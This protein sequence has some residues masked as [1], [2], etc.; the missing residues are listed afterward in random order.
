MGD[1]KKNSNG[2]CR[3]LGVVSLMMKFQMRQWIMDA[4]G[5]H[6]TDD[7]TKVRIWPAELPCG[8][9]PRRIDEA[10]LV[11]PRRGV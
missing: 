5:C 11:K 2:S 3:N 1:G 6:A 10:R 7:K 4:W 9:G 8:A